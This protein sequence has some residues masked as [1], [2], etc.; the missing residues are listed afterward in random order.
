MR[1]TDGRPR[2]QPVDDLH[3]SRDTT[4]GSTLHSKTPNYTANRESSLRPDSSRRRAA[5]H[6]VDP[7]TFPAVSAYRARIVI[8]HR[9]AKRLVEQL[10]SSQPLPPAGRKRAFGA[11]LSSCRVGNRCCGK[12]KP[13]VWHTRPVRRRDVTRSTQGAIESARRRTHLELRGLQSE[14]PVRPLLV[15]VLHE[16]GQ[17]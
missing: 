6:F 12:A 4:L 2:Q 7:V 9:H 13:L 3:P 17:H 10:I 16:F 5:D 1:T 15:V 14:R 8:G 11:R